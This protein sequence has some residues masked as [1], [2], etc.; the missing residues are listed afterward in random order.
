MVECSKDAVLFAEAECCAFLLFALEASGIYE[1]LLPFSGCTLVECSKDGVLS[2]EPECSAFLLFELEAYGMVG[3][4]C[5]A[6]A[7]ACCGSAV[8]WTESSVVAELLVLLLF[9]K[10]DLNSAL[11]RQEEWQIWL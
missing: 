11:P 2:T 1:C 7:G 6:W 3:G 5:V 9:S 8:G 4:T 10:L